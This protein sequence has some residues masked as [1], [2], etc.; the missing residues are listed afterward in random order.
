MAKQVNETV[1]DRINRELFIP[2][3]QFFV[4][5]DTELG[6]LERAI[7]ISDKPNIGNSDFVPN[8]KQVSSFVGFVLEYYVKNVLRLFGSTRE[9][10]HE[11]FP[12]GT[13]RSGTDYFTDKYGKIHFRRGTNEITEIDSLWMFNDLELNIPIIFEIKYMRRIIGKSSV[14]LKF[15]N[16]IYGV[17]PIYCHVRPVADSEEIPGFHGIY[18]NHYKKILIPRQDFHKIAKHVLVGHT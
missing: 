14:K 3:A 5:D 9:G 4:N 12:E 16:E 6:E 18:S 2:L 15:I 10:F 7:L 11:V 17:Y 8:S 13:I 1:R